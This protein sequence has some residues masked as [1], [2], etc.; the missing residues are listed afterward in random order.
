M[1]VKDSFCKVVDMVISLLIIG[2]LVWIFCFGFY[3]LGRFMYL[4]SQQV[5]YICPTCHQVVTE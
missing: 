3:T 4:D 2:F 5:N 1:R